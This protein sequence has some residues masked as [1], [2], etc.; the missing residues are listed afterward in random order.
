MY[1]GSN[2]WR[3]TAKLNSLQ[4]SY[5]WFV[6]ALEDERLIVKILHSDL[7]SDFRSLAYLLLHVMS[8]DKIIAMKYA[9]IQTDSM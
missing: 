9:R 3:S 5:S 2:V 1:S 4:Q 6:Q 8:Y 7:Q